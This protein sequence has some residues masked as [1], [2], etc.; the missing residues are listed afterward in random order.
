MSSSHNAMLVDDPI[1]HLIGL[2]YW[3][4]VSPK[5]GSRSSIAI[6]V[7]G[8]KGFER[9]PETLFPRGTVHNTSRV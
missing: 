2:R 9:S 7:G 6:R 8:V 3:V 1:E 4:F 5:D